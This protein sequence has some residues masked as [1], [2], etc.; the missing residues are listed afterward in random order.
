MN[1]TTLAV[2]NY[3]MD[4]LR[5]VV[6]F[7]VV[8]LHGT[9]TYMEYAP[10]W[11]YVLDSQRSIIFTYMVLLIDVP[12]M[13][14]MFFLSGYF[15]WPSLAKRG[16]ALFFRDKIR[17]IGIP[18]VFGV[19]VLAPPTGY[20]IY[21]SRHAPMS[22][23][24]FWQTDA[25]GKAYQQSVYWYL[26]V[27]LALFAVTAAL[28]AASRRFAA[29]TPS[30]RAPT[31]R[32]GALFILAVSAVSAAIATRCDLDLWSNNYLF[33]YQPVRIPNYVGYFFLGIFAYQ[34]GWFTE[35][36]F[37]PRLGL[38][39]PLGSI[40][41]LAYL[42]WRLSPQ[43]ATP[44]IEFKT[45]AILLFNLFCLTSLFAMMALFRRYFAS[46]RPFWRYQ[47]RNS[48]GVYYLHP[49]ILYP[50]ALLFA[51]L[52]LSIFLKAAII[53]LLAYGISLAASSL[54]LTRAPGLRSM[55]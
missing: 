40:S 11:W 45:V 6:I 26:G 55:F 43:A 10:P 33:A 5:V 22:L 36:G 23:W 50:L 13:Q 38:W 34:S 17:R 37:Q 41:G 54:V 39:V 48:Y 15:A 20:M 35:A 42:M 1:G 2:R 8:V 49:L 52:S 7:L 19:L 24:T 18:W 30:V 31:W 44:T 12:I 28:F 29:W 46:D 25:W 51:P 16:P 27:L 53:I 21:Y 47:A 3:A 32:Q 14:I 4:N 9:I